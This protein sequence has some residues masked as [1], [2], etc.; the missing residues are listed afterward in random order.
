M[1]GCQLNNAP[2]LRARNFEWQ[3]MTNYCHFLAAEVSRCHLEA[4]RIGEPEHLAVPN[5]LLNSLHAYKVY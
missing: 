3:S 5:R 1:P 4:Y 2:W